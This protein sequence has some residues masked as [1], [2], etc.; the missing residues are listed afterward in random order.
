MDTKILP[1]CL[2][3]FRDGILLAEYADDGTGRIGE[4]MDC[5]QDERKD[6]PGGN[7]L[8]EGFAQF[9]QFYEV[10]NAL[11]RAMDNFTGADEAGN[12]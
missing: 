4:G 10:Q 12:G 5:F 3:Y 6:I 9:V 1:A 7:R 2:H 11:I 8:L